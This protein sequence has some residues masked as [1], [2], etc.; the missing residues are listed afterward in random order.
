MRTIVQVEYRNG[1][2][3]VREEILQFLG[4]PFT[5]LNM[6]VFAPMPRASVSTAIAVNPGLFR[7]TLK[8]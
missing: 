8:P 4:H 1:L 2:L 3:T 7:S 6:A 5:T